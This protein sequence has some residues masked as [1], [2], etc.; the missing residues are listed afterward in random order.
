MTE[1][2]YR[3]E[4]LSHNEWQSALTWARE[5]RDRVLRTGDPGD[6]GAAF[7][8]LLVM[9]LYDTGLVKLQ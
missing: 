4:Y 2:K 7:A 6:H 3:T 9:E 1:K 5:Q 8:G